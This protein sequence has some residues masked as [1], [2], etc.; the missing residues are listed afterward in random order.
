MQASGVGLFMRTLLVILVLATSL[1]AQSAQQP[2]AQPQQAPAGHGILGNPEK[3]ADAHLSAI[4]KAVTLTDEQKP[5]L[6][7]IFVNEAKKLGTILTDANVTDIQ[8]QRNIQSL[9]LATIHQVATELTPDQREKFFNFMPEA[10]PRPG[11]V[12]N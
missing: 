10:R 2:P 7:A 5:R 12:Q 9:H 1:A 11:V 8:R 4:D 6:R 3:F